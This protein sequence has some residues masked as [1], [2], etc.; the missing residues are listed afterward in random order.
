MRYDHDAMIGRSSPLEAHRRGGCRREDLGTVEPWVRDYLLL[1]PA[2]TL[3]RSRIE[4]AGPAGTPLP[5]ERWR[6]YCLS[7]VTTHDLAAD[8]RRL[9]GR[10]PGTA[11]CESLGLLTNPVEAWNP[12]SAPGRRAPGWP[13][14]AV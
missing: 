9:P 4:I 2:T 1:R 3:W 7:S 12:E 14:C 8:R 11:G 6:E 5:A 13:S 10:R